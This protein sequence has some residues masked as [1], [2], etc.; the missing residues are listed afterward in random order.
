MALRDIEPPGTQARLLGTLVPMAVRAIR[1]VWY[2]L[3]D[4]AAPRRLPLVQ[5]DEMPI[6]HSGS[7]RPAAVAGQEGEPRTMPKH[8]ITLDD[9]LPFTDF[10]VSAVPAEPATRTVDIVC[11]EQTTE[12]KTRRAP[13][14]PLTVSLSRWQV[15]AVLA[16]GR[17]RHSTVTA[18]QT[19]S[20]I[21]VLKSTIS[22]Q[23]DD[24]LAYHRP[25][26][27]RTVSR[28]LAPRFAADVPDDHHGEV[29]LL[30]NICRNDLAWLAETTPYLFAA[31]HSMLAVTNR[32]DIEARWTALHPP[33]T[34]TPVTRRWWWPW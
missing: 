16:A 31:D 4:L 32:S 19:G 15:Q 23:I 22:T 18:P 27:G 14:P 26:L 5:M 33:P 29:L 34:V 25:R 30:L 21:E 20:T 2:R 12:R 13:A 10:I 9:V 11:Q 3:D 24:H 1:I 8:L 6:V 17:H 28:P 7:T